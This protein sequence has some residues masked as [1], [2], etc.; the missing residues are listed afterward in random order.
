MTI[1]CSSVEKERDGSDDDNPYMDLLVILSVS[2][3]LIV[4]K[5]NYRF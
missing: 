3:D 2:I 1:F 5:A 4:P